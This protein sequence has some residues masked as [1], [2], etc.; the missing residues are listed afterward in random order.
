MLHLAKR[1]FL[2]DKIVMFAYPS[3]LFSHQGKMTN[4]YFVTCT[5]ELDGTELSSTHKSE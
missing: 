5:S 2:G 1:S 3:V 4:K